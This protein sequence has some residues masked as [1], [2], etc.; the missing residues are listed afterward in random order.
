M[1]TPK[2]LAVFGGNGFLGSKICQAALQK[3]WKVISV[4]RSG[5][6]DWK[7]STKNGHRPEW[8]ESVTWV[9]ADIFEP[10]SYKPHLASADAVVHSMGLLLEADYKDVLRGKENPISGLRKAFQA[11]GSAWPKSANPLDKVPGDDVASTSTSSSGDAGRQMSYEKLNRDSALIAAKQFVESSSTK[12]KTFVYIS[13]AAGFPILPQRYISSKR[14]AE[15]LLAQV[16]D[17][18]SIFFR[19]GFMFSYERPITVPMG[20]LT[21]VSATMNS[22]TG[23]IFGGLLGAAGT[24]PMD[25]E[26]VGRAVVQAIDDESIKGPVEVPLIETLS[27]RLT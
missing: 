23:N 14:E 12:P 19:P 17:F 15:E 4:S 6:P 20:Y 18:R 27:S 21:K 10:A 25:V 16:P 24:A 9:S 26:K 22:L 8:A 13:A 11:G 1:A 3:N 7:T 2:C 5:E